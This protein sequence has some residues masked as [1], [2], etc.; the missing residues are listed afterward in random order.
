MK[1]ATS[2]EDM[3][4]GDYDVVQI[5]ESMLYSVVCHKIGVDSQA[6]ISSACFP[7]G[8]TGGWQYVPRDE[9]PDGWWEGP[10]AVAAS[11]TDDGHDAPYPQPCSDH[12][13]THIHL[14]AA[15]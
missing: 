15:C 2:A 13:E 3:K 6:A 12:P 9:L 5:H 11:P 7:A 10:G 4:A 14:L 8:T 1:T